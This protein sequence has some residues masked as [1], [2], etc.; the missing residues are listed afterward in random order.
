MESKSD[1]K[2]EVLTEED[3]LLQDLLMDDL[4]TMQTPVPYIEDV[5]D[6]G[7]REGIKKQASKII[8]LF[9]SIL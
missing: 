8:L 6:V 1:L 3:L 9:N 7:I 2:L 5:V 4:Q